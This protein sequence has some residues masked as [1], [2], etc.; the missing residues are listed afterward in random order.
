MKILL[1]NPPQRGVYGASMAPLYPPLGLLYVAAVLEG[2]GHVVRLLDM[3]AEAIDVEGFT[4]LL[5]EYGP[6]VVGLT[7]VTP[8]YPAARALGASAR[9]MGGCT[10]VMGGPHA[11]A[12]PGDVLREAGADVV[13]VGEGERTLAE[14]VRALG[15]QAGLEGVPGLA[16][17]EDGEVR[18]SGPRPLLEDLDDLPLPA[19]Y[20]LRQP[21]GYRPTD[22]RARPVATL[23]ASRGCPGRCTFCAS[24]LIAG[25]RV[26][27]RS[28]E[29]IVEE[30]RYLRRRCG[31]REVHLVDDCF[32][33]GRDAVLE[34][35]EEVARLGL[36]LSF[37]F[38]NGLRADMVDRDV[39][40]SL[41]SMGTWSVGYGVEDADPG[42][43][44]R[45]GKPTDL[46]RVREAVSLAA[47][48]GM[49]TWV[50]FMIGLPGQSHVSLQRSV[51]FAL[52]LD[53]DYAKFE[54]FKPYPGTAAWKEL[55]DSG[56]IFERDWSRYGIHTPPVHRLPGLGGREM[57]GWRRRAHRAFYLRSGKAWR[58]MRRAFAGAKPNPSAGVFLLRTML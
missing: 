3:D 21:L 48:L 38:C 11:T 30:L 37:L 25:R 43:L 26:R 47:A 54:I 9:A 12:L 45:A 14:L 33:A 35:A 5:K 20:L 28:T 42:I 19:R 55:D 52:E 16:W 31:V 56:L 17:L 36:G 39:L 15:E 10:V 2:E 53:P 32:T 51:R 34:T 22:A 58:H 4:L 7:A 57:L 23:L 46:E 8:T 1:V 44:E 49:T 18:F 6:S 29:A 27:R 50:F 24:H 40:R 13:V 41:R